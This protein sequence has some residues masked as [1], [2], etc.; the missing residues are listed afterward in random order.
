MKDI[1][2]YEG[3]YAIT[4]E[5]QVWSYY[6]KRFIKPHIRSNGYLQVLLSKGG[7]K[8]SYKVHRLVAQAYLPNPDNLPEV[9]HID[10]DKTNNCVNNLEWCSHE[11]NL[12]YGQHNEKISNSLKKRCL[13]VELNKEF[14]SINE[15]G[16]FIKRN[17]SGV[18]A[19]LNGKQ[20]TAGGY[21]WQYI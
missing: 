17:P 20:K 12:N 19:A 18:S 11:Y 5:G 8:K 9:N 7:I 4:E 16:L 14:N 15:A 10:E 13:C 2:G 3:L 6:S 1:K 21:H